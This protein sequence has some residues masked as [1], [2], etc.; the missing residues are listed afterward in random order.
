M[1]NQQGRKFHILQGLWYRY[2]VDCKVDETK[3][4][5][6]WNF[7]RNLSNLNIL[8]RELVGQ[9]AYRLTLR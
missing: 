5:T 3:K 8:I 4:Y 6:G 1:D 9:L 2:L 7:E